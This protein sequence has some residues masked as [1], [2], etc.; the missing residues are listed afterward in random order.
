MARTQ[1]WIKTDAVSSFSSLTFLQLLA[2]D[3]DNFLVPFQ[4][5]ICH[6]RNMFTRDP[7]VDSSLDRLALVA[8]R[9]ANFD[10]FWA[11]ASTSYSRRYKKLLEKKIQTGCQVYGLKNPLPEMGSFGLQDD[12]GMRAAIITLHQSMSPGSYPSTLQLY[13]SAF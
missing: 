5:D 7:H 10:A 3:G 9:R 1:K 12:L 6:F 2:R 8:I 11:R 4:C 13:R